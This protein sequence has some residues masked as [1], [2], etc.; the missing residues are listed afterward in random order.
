[1]IY[2]PKNITTRMMRATEPITTETIV[3]RKNT[4][5][6]TTRTTEKIVTG[7]IHARKNITTKATYTTNL[8]RSGCA[9]KIHTL[10]VGMILTTE[11]FTPL[12]ASPLR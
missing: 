8:W 10:T 7:L 1:M 4:T 5:T 6:G 2:A 11:K 3:T 12:R 9:T